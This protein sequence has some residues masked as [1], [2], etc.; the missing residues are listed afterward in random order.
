MPEVVPVD[1]E[2]TVVKSVYELVG[3][4]IFHVLLVEEPI[5]AE[6]HT[7]VGAESAR[8]SLRTRMTLYR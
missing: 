8:M 3:D 2:A 4:G 7:V 5:L 6:E 1:L